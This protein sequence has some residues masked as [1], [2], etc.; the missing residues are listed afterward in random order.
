VRVAV[1]FKWRALGLI[2]VEAQRLRFPDVA[3][4]PGIYQFNLGDRLYIGESDRLRRR[5]QHYRTPGVGQPTNIR[6]NVVMSEL[7]VQGSAV[8]VAV[9]TSASVEV[10]G[11]E[12]PLDLTRKSARLLVENAALTAERVAGRLVENL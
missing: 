5:F 8:D 11:R 2:R 10:D 3:D 12:S 1:D 4:V 6:L 7:L 9:I